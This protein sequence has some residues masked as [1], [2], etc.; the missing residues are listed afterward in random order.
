MLDPL[1]E[2]HRLRTDAAIL[3]AGSG[4][5][6]QDAVQ[7]FGFIQEHCRTWPVTAM[8]R[9]L[10]VSPS[11]FYAWRTRPQNQWTQRRGQLSREITGI[12]EES[13]RTYGSPRVHAELVARG[14]PCCQKTVAKIM[15]CEGLQAA[16]RRTF[17]LT[18]DSNHTL[19][20]AENLLDRKFA[21]TCPNQ[22]WVND[23][24]AVP[25]T[26]GWLYLVA[27][28]DLF[29]RR[30]VGWSLG[31]KRTSEL[32][33]TALQLALAARRPQPGLLHHSDRGSQYAC[34]DFQNLLASHGIVCSMSRKGNC[35]DNAVMESFFGTLKQE[36]LQHHHFT[37][38]D[39]AE[40]AIVEYISSFYNQHRRHSTLD[41]LSP[42]AYEARHEA[43][44]VGG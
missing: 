16:I 24:M 37:T 34:H 5:L 19:P 15:R 9:V 8:C 13:R 12:F 4:L 41:Y 42:A 11:G 18:T 3:R 40:Q 44:H 35:W 17:Q 7:R 31:H 28:L 27:I 39:E 22:A 33:I 29:S 38:R 21:P 30:A 36:L 6:Q 14:I 43:S 32:V 1:Q 20:V 23:I 26:E 10:G 2:L 25:T